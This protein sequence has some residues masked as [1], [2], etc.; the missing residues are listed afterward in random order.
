MWSFSEVHLQEEYLKTRLCRDLIYTWKFNQDTLIYGIIW[1]NPNSSL[2][3]RGAI[4]KLLFDTKVNTVGKSNHLASKLKAMKEF[5]FNGGFWFSSSYLHVN[6]TIHQKKH[7]KKIL[8]ISDYTNWPTCG[9]FH[10]RKTLY[11][12]MSHLQKLY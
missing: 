6:T 4:K 10:I 9:F 12:R 1:G 2:L 5:Y 11:L 8:C 3:F 7:S